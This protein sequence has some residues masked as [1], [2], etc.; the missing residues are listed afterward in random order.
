VAMKNV[1][2]VFGQF[3]EVGTLL[4]L[5]LIFEGMHLKFARPVF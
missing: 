3:H 2:N 4:R 5:P 1:G